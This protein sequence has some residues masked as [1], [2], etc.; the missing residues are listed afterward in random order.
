MV[1]GTAAAVNC[2]SNEEAL[3][4]IIVGPPP[5]EA[6]AAAALMAVAT[7]QVEAG[8]WW[9]IGGVDTAVRVVGSV[10]GGGSDVSSG[11]VVCANRAEVDSL[12]PPPRLLAIR[13][14]AS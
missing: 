8:V 9:D 1:R 11:I 4:A 7:D 2:C 10:V 6:S 12:V 5:E 14:L 13:A 3:L